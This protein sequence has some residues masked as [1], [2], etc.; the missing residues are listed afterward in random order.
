MAE[1]VDALLRERDDG[2]AGFKSALAVLYVV[3]AVLARDDDDAE[4]AE[5]DLGEAEELGVRRRREL[6]RAA[7]GRRQPQPAEL[8]VARRHARARAVR[9]DLHEAADLLLRD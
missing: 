5:R 4:R 9:A 3:D 7:R 8:L 1:H 6:E 2:G